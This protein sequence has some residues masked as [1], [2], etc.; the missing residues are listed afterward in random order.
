M[1]PRQRNPARRNWPAHLREREG[2]YSW[3]HPETGREYGIGRNKAEAFEEAKEANLHVA[4]RMQKARLVHKLTGEHERTVAKWSVRFEGYLAERKLSPNTRKMYASCDKRLVRM[5]GADTLIGSVTPLQMSE[6]IEKIA[7]TENKPRRAI[8]VR[9]YAS[10]FFR[11]AKVKGWVA[12]SPVEDLG[13]IQVTTKR[14]RLTF[15]VFMLVYSTTTFGWLKNAMALA[16]VSAQRREDIA[17]FETSQWRDGGWHCEQGKGNPDKGGAGM[18]GSRLII[19][20]ALRLERFGMSLDEV[21]RQCRASRVFTRYVI[22]HTTH[23]GKHCKVGDPV[24]MDTLTVRFHMEIQRLAI[25]WGDKEPPSFHEIRSLSERLYKA[26]GGINTQVLL[27][28]KSARS[29]ETYDDDR[30]SE[31]TRVELAK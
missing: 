2:Y 16:L 24:H 23:R 27:G 29:T 31:W 15:D 28:H 8:Q 1:A 6:L 20:G 3:V 17:L 11:E 12:E 9:S 21:Y 14:A 5:L 4:A 19:P 10:E 30:R 13:A 22:H 18:G 7:K 26:Q 25:D